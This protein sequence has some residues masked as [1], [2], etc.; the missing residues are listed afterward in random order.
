MTSTNVDLVRSICTRWG[1]GDFGSTAWADP[2]IEFGGSSPTRTT[3]RALAELGLDQ[4]S[5]SAGGSNIPPLRGP[6]VVD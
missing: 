4:D 3:P 2:D 5:G 6:R 1:R